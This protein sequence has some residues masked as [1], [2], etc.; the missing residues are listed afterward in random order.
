[1][2]YNEEDSLQS[3]FG[4]R[5]NVSSDPGM[6]RNHGKWTFYGGDFFC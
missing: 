3:K 5:L 2:D 4:D 1:M 6:D